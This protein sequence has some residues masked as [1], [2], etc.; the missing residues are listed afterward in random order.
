MSGRTLGV[1]GNY[2]LKVQILSIPQL[3]VLALRMCVRS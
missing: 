3:E 1:L 2:H